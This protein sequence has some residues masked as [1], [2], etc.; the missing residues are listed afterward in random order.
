MM[1]RTR[2]TPVAFL[3]CLAAVGT[4][5]ALV[6]ASASARTVYVGNAVSRSVTPIDT[7]SNMPGTAIPIGEFAAPQAIAIDLDGSTA[8]LLDLGDFMNDGPGLVPIDTETNAVGTKIP[9]GFPPIPASLAISPDG[10]TAYVGGNNEMGA[11]RLIPVD[12]TTGTPGTAIPVGASL[13][14][15]LAFTPGGETLYAVIAD[16]NVFP[17]DLTTVTPTPGTAIPVGT[18]PAGIAITPDG[19]KAYVA[20]TGSDNVTPINLTSNTPGT[21]IPAGDGP[22]GIAMSPDGGHAYVTKLN[23]DDVTVIDT[24][25]DQAAASTFDVGEDPHGI[26]I[27]PDGSTAYVT[28]RADNNVSPIDI[29]TPAVGS[30]ITVGTFPTGL[31]IVPNQ[32]PTADFSATPAPAEEATTFDGSGSSDTDGTVARYDWDFGDGE[33]LEDGGPAPTHLY[34]EPGTY[35]VTL[36]VTDDEG[37]SNA[38]VF[39]GQTAHC[40]GSALAQFSDDVE[41][42]EPPAPPGPTPT[43]PQAIPNQLSLKVKRKA[44]TRPGRSCFKVVAIANGAPVQGVVVRLGRKTRQTRANGRARICIRRKA[45]ARRLR[46]TAQK[47]GFAAISREVRIPARRR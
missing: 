30:P 31:A 4:W 22:F 46:I 10:E 28:N 15:A 45:E 33:T 2:V 27:T 47:P 21:A 19:S 5:L 43:N 37:C 40:N 11:G 18:N 32:G 26:A 42:A 36:T 7:D 35:T 17:I 9:L 1:Q 8:W 39:T 41:V 38:L 12:L 34:A 25:T 23:D 20:N 13:V 14:T 3:V 16:G 6:A 44:R 29:L 24:A